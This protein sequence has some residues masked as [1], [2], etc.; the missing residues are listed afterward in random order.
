MSILFLANVKNCQDLKDF[1]TKNGNDAA[2]FARNA[3][4]LYVHTTSSTYG[5]IN[6]LK[7][8]KKVYSTVYGTIFVYKKN[9]ENV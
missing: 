4:Q 9:Y 3:V 6:P 5:E 7:K 1:P 2:K 8:K